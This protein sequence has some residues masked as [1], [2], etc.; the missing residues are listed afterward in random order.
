M[1]KTS[2]QA[3]WTPPPLRKL[4]TEALPAS[5]FSNFKLELGLV[6]SHL[7]V[8]DTALQDLIQA[9][10]P[11]ESTKTY[12]RSRTRAHGHRRLSTDTLDI[13]FAQRLAYISQIA[14]LLSKL[15]QLCRSVRRHDLVSAE[16]NDR[17]KG[18]F[19]RKCLWSLAASRESRSIPNPIDNSTA[20]RY[21]PAL[22]LALFDHYRLT[23]NDTLHASDSQ[24]DPASEAGNSQREALVEEIKSLNCDH[25]YGQL[26][27]PGQRL[28]FADV[29]LLSKSTQSIAR[30]LCR[31]LADPRR[32]LLPE[33][34]R[35][36]GNQKPERR[37][38][39][40]VAFLAQDYLLDDIEI[41]ALLSEDAW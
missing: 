12:L 1:T 2:A 30:S 39:A 17:A 21:V 16:L 28:S 31:S 36:F 32:D 9:C 4:A 35:R 41:R 20:T 38:N 13:G 14:L 3:P 33:I 25:T 5:I 6:N 8:I 10:Q 22:D 11:P 40:A 27:S 18:D 29:L 37:R 15:E 23:R 7:C 19:L 26:P 24:Q 34:R